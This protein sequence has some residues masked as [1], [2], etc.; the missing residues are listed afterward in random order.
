ML[1]CGLALMLL[2]ATA[3]AF[4]LSLPVDCTLGDTCYIQH[5]VDRDRGPGGRD[6]YN[7]V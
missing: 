5:Y 6:S 2:P 3:E 7:F 1:I 4:S